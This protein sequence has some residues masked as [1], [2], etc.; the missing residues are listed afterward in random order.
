[1]LIPTNKVTVS[2]VLATTGILVS[3]ALSLFLLTP[4]PG[5]DTNVWA[6]PPPDNTCALWTQ[7]F[8]E[9]INVWTYPPPLITAPD[10]ALSNICSDVSDEAPTLIVIEVFVVSVIVTAVSYTHLRAHET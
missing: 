2:A 7:L 5:E 10:V 6:Y 9:S 4:P 3:N 8:A 1:M